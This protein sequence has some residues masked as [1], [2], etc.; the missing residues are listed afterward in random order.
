MPVTR[1]AATIDKQMKN[2]FPT[3]QVRMQE[4]G[5][6]G[7]IGEE[8]D[9]SLTEGWGWSLYPETRHVNSFPQNMQP[10][11]D[12]STEDHALTIVR[13]ISASINGVKLIPMNGSGMKSKES[14]NLC[15][16]TINLGEVTKKVKINSGCWASTKS[17]SMVTKLSRIQGGRLGRFVDID[18]REV[19]EESSVL[20]AMCQATTTNEEMTLQSDMCFQNRDLRYSI[21]WLGPDI[22]GIYCALPPKRDIFN[23]PLMFDMISYFFATKLTYIVL[24]YLGFRVPMSAGDTGPACAVHGLL[25]MEEEMEHYFHTP[26]SPT[27]T[28]MHPYPHHP[29][30]ALSIIVGS[31]IQLQSQIPKM[32]F[33]LFNTMLTEM[34]VNITSIREHV[35]IKAC[36]E[37]L[38]PTLQS[39]LGQQPTDV[40]ELDFIVYD[41][42][43]LSAKNNV[44]ALFSPQRHLLGVVSWATTGMV[45]TFK[46]M[47]AS[48]ILPHI[49]SLG[50]MGYPILSSSMTHSWTQRCLYRWALLYSCWCRN[51]MEGDFI[52]HARSI[53]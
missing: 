19:V 6:L 39:L 22:C 38:M 2:N 51:F 41:L 5:L 7:M 52:C 4:R 30:K 21:V 32:L 17:Q 31:K 24:S 8:T 45:V 40:N 15:S 28:Y 18:S 37:E 42:I 49:V 26:P 9:S 13:E 46:L 50:P 53:S 3:D 23:D 35:C 43:D 25:E 14:G 16:T 29:K 48:S 33:N 12:E 27:K 1:P 47:R 44:T 20:C 36:L 10:F 11:A 34:E